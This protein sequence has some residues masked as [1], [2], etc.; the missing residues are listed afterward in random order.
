MQNL[1]VLILKN[2][3]VIVSEIHEVAGA[4]L[5]EPDCKLVNP[6][7]LKQE[8]GKQYMEQWPPFTVQREIKIHSDSIFTIVDPKPDLIELY[9]KAIQ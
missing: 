9:L 4:D 7:I 6:C 1:K 2:D 3:A 8:L 5:G